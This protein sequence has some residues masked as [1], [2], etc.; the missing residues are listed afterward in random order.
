MTRK[1]ARTLFTAALLAMA[2]PFLPGCPGPAPATE[3]GGTTNDGGTTTDGGGGTDTGTP[4]TDGGGGDP[5]TGISPV[6]GGP[7]GGHATAPL[8]RHSVTMEDLALAREA[9]RIMGAS[10]AGG[11]SSCSDCH[12]MTRP[13]I[14]HFL[15]ISTTAWSSCFSDLAV[16]TPEAARA[17]VA[18]FQDEATHTFRPSHLGVFSSGATLAW[19]Q[20]VFQQAYG[21]SWQ[22]EYDT[23]V[24]R[25]QQS[26]RPYA[27]LTQDEFDIVTEWFLRGTPNVADVIPIIQDPGTCVPY[28]DASVAGIVAQG[29]TNGWTAR[30]A[31]AGI[32]MHGCAG[33][34]RP[35]DCLASYPRVTT[36]TYGAEWETPGTHQ[37]VLFDTSYA[38][39]Y[40]T[41]SSADGRFVAHGGGVGGG[42]SIV[43]LQRQVAV[44][45]SAAYDPGFFPDNSGFMFQGTP[46]GAGL[47]NQSVLMVGSPTSI[48]FSEAGCTHPT[49]IGLYQH[50]G[51]SLDGGDY[52]VVNSLWSGDPGGSL[53][54][55]Q[56]F[57]DPASEVTLFRLMNTGT[58]FVAGGQS[59]AITPYEGNSVISPTMRLLVGSLADVSG[60]PI[61]YAL[62]RIVLTRDGTGAV[63]NVE[64][65]EVARYCFPG[66]KPA[67]SLDDRWLVT[68]HRAT[69]ADAVD[70]GFTGP[71]D[72]GFAAY[73]GVSN[74]YLIDLVTGEETR[75]TNM[76]PGQQ[77]LFPHFRSDGWIYFLA[78]T[79]GVPEHIVASDAALVL[80]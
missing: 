22:T 17:I 5:D 33:A 25:V 19:F 42:A 4:P 70:L 73:R 15:T 63:T 14:A 60:N 3:D 67:F 65:P 77:A 10:A 53:S 30:N 66:G 21:A 46:F 31:E 69:D 62:H 51:A 50:V 37:R 71:T 7:D 76:Q 2:A 80:R 47:C 74:A 34:T 58:G 68:H 40:W 8:L 49:R 12:A 32:L 39:S 72:P 48:N 79:G 35:E 23:F 45:V 54:D 61:G 1:T 29:Q 38:T 27:P 18:C 9:L 13:S 55:P 64:L 11:T 52:F 6:D 75:I 78:R 24:N 59:S 16:E 44:H 36:T 28:V 57:V 20:F 43:D 26:P 56:V 41:R